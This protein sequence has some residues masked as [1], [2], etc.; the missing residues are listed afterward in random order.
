MAQWPN[1]LIADARWAS[2]PMLDA[3][4]LNTCQTNH[5]DGSGKCSSIKHQASS[6]K[7]SAIRLW[8]C[9]AMKP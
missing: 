2:K 8:G 5:K 7:L 4:C 9:E 1:R 6:I 3:C